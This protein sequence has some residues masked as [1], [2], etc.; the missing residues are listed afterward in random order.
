MKRYL[1]KSICRIFAGILLV[2]ALTA[3]LQAAKDGWKPISPEDLSL[4]K[5]RVEEN[6][7]AEALFWEVRVED[8]D[9]GTVLNHYIRIK[10][11]NERGRH[12]QSTIDIPFAKWLRVDR[13]AGRTI[14]PDGTIVELDKKSIYERTLAKVG[15]FKIEV[16]SFALPAV[17][18]GSIIEYRW[19]ETR[20]GAWSNYARFDFQ[21]EIP[22]QEVTYYIKAGSYRYS[23]VGMT[24]N[25][26]RTPF[27]QEDDGFFSTSMTNVPA[28]RDEKDMPPE[29]NVR[30]WMLLYYT[31]RADGIS[32]R[33]FW[34][35]FGRQLYGKHKPEMK[36][37]KNIKRLAT[38]LTLGSSTPEEKLRRIFDYCRTQIRSVS[39]DAAEKTEKEIKKAVKS[40]SPSDT[41]KRGYGTSLDID[42][43]F[44]A[45]AKAAGFEARYALMGDRSD[46]FFSPEMTNAYFLRYGA[47]AVLREGRWRFFS[48][49]TRHIPFGMLRWQMEA[50]QALVSDPEEPVFAE[51]PLARAEQSLTRRTARLKLRE[52]GLVEGA[53][54]IEYTGHSSAWRREW[55]DDKTPQERVKMVS[56]TVQG[57]FKD[58]EISQVQVENLADAEKPLVYAWQL[59]MPG[60][61]QATGKR[62]FFQPAFFQL[63][64]SP[65]F[66]AGDRTH[67][68]Y[69]HY[70]WSEEDEVAI[71]LPEG[72]TAEAAGSPAPIR[73]EKVVQYSAQVASS[74]NQIIYRR[75]FAF[76]GLFF[77]VK[78]YPGIKRI[79]EDI[80]KRDTHT[81]IL[82]QSRPDV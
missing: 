28:F 19:R 50:Q 72:M 62:L 14:Q 65:R 36:V 3:V 58:A 55:L 38:Q 78:S 32:P 17:E 76:R 44:A 54:R 60:Y 18:P 1:S 48:P 22:V 4:Q 29:P 63:G 74:G 59:R 34:T 66:T 47:V 21:R 51:T 20:K 11:F 31:R 35:D 8:Q 25:G 15:G 43:L 52:D 64:S 79:F 5:P 41:I 6:A 49:S 42:Q 57:W 30:S 70:L 75:S 77:P 73:P 82:K 16:K 26:S 27:Q 12:S 39:D 81:L 67:R 71:E 2:V 24:F 13:I 68:I 53:C 33:K 23:M 9:I 69:F 61:A 10:I 45:L 56:E 37:D 7:D 80:H 40:N 46:Y